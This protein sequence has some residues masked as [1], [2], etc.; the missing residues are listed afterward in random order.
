MGARFIK[1]NRFV[2]V[3][4]AFDGALNGI[5]LNDV[6]Y[7]VPFGIAAFEFYTTPITWRLR[8]WLML[9]T[10]VVV[11]LSVQLSLAYI[12]DGAAKG[13]SVVLVQGVSLLILNGLILA[14]FVLT[15]RAE[16]V[17]SASM[18]K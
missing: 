8:R 18:K 12:F 4:L 7:V 14:S 3:L 1:N 9:F 10:V 13:A 5:Y 15:R 6:F 2:A 16:E 17:A 11:V